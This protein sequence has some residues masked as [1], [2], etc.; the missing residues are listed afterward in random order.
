[1]LRYNLQESAKTDL[2][3]ML[4]MGPAATRFGNGFAL[5]RM[6]EVVFYLFHEINAG[7]EHRDFPSGFEELPHYRA[8]FRESES[9]ASSSLKEAAVHA[10]SLFMHERIKDNLSGAKRLGFLPFCNVVALSQSKHRML[11]PACRPTS[12]NLDINSA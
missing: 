9:S 10:V 8:P 5:L 7:L 11:G 1:M 3:R 4:S 6:C 12:P 2:V